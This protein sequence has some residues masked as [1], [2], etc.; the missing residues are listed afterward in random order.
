MT[1]EVAYLYCGGKMWPRLIVSLWTLRKHWA[2]DVR[3]YCATEK[4]VQWIVPTCAALDCVPVLMD[5]PN[6][7]GSS[8]R[9]KLALTQNVVAEN[10]V[11]ID[12]DTV[13]EGD[14]SPMFGHAVV[15]T[16]HGNWT[17]KGRRVREQLVSYRGYSDLLDPWINIQLQDEYPHINAGTFSFHRGCT[18][19]GVWQILVAEV[20][21]VVADNPDVFTKRTTHV[22]ADT[23]FQLIAG[24]FPCQTILDDRYN[25]C[26][27]HGLHWDDP[28]V[29]HYCG[30]RHGR[31]D[32]HWRN[33]F[34]ECRERNLGGICD[35]PR[36]YDMET[37]NML[38]RYEAGMYDT[39]DGLSKGRL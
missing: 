13:V 28:I 32:P 25:C 39:P 16:S 7:S 4:D 8:P 35:H 21:R 9:G 30:R 36:R 33:A 11:Y 20:V 37:K 17:T 27:R 14:I 18:Q 26:C 38:K 10:I 34:L 2:G 31:N 24:Q 15:L 1:R 22:P 12:A 5:Q 29:R 19:I 3:V 23:A 6:A